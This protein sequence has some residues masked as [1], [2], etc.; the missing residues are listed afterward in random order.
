RGVIFNEQKGI[1]TFPLYVSWTELSRAMFPGLPYA[2]EHGGTPRDVPT[3]TYDD[4][5]DFHD[6]FYHPA[7]ARL[8]TWG[9]VPL[10][11]I[12]STVDNALSRVPKRPFAATPFPRLA[13]DA[14]PQHR[15]A[16]LAT[17]AG[18]DAKGMV[19]MAWSAGQATDS[20]DL[21]LYDV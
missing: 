5:K 3:I 18:G 10:E 12:G 8:I 9:D 4:L 1:F 2:L 16:K 21:L 14:T 6:R 7:G 17:A 13:Q 19:L 15:V 11:E 20:Y